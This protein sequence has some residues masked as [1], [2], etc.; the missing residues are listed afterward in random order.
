MNNSKQADIRRQVALKAA[1]RVSDDRQEALTSAEMFLK[2]LNK[3][4]E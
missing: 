3:V 1:S 2:W 4:E